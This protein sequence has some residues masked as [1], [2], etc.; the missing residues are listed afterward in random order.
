M[1]AVAR[2]VSTVLAA[3]MGMM[4]EGVQGVGVR[5]AA[6]DHAAPMSAVPAVGSA[7]R[8]AFVTMEC[9]DP[10]AA[11]ASAGVE[12]NTVSEYDSF[13]GDSG[14]GFVV[15]GNKKGEL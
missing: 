11:I 12:L 2:A 10:V 5:V 8:V 6:H 1:L 7:E 14:V 4:I 3:L 15:L 9:H 13:H